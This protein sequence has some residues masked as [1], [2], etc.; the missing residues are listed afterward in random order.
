MLNDKRKNGRQSVHFHRMAETKKLLNVLSN[1]YGYI[2]KD[3]EQGERYDYSLPFR[4][5]E[6]TVTLTGRAAVYKHNDYGL[7]IYRVV[8]AGNLD[9]YGRPANY[10]L[11][12]ANGGKV[13]NVKADDPDLIILQDNFK[14]EP[15]S[16]LADRYGEQLGK[17]RETIITNVFTMRTPFLLSAEKEQILSV[18][19]ALEA[20]N[21]APYVLE[22][23]SLG[24]DQKSIQ[25]A[26]LKT[27]DNLKSLEDEYNTTFSKFKEE[28]GFSSNNVDKKE[29]LVA[30][31]AEDDN[32]TLIAFDNEPYEN[33]IKF[34]KQM[35]KK[36]GIKLEL[37]KANI[38]IYHRQKDTIDGGRPIDKNLGKGEIKSEET[39]E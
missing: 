2:F 7:S 21:E 36:F 31:E 6:N 22:D 1:R 27:P 25:V 18:R 33:R 29:R 11:Y 13:M 35:D 28:I 15:L 20:M 23:K 9:I 5:L 38:D 30:A 14:G 37:I 16:L 24:M 10:F 4:Y 8:M 39:K 12:T 17:I 32:S 19:L 3:E 34:I 26:D